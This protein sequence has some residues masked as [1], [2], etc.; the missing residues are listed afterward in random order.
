MDYSAGPE[1][2]RPIKSSMAQGDHVG[3]G[4]QMHNGDSGGNLDMK[5]S[6]KVK[7]VR[8]GVRAVEVNSRVDR[9]MPHT[10]YTSG[11]HLF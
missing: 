1:E 10:V 8:G 6:N 4:M 2:K 7:F 5:I 11:R 3:Q 9:I